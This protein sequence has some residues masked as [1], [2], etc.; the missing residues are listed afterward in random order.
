MYSSG[1]KNLMGIDLPFDEP[2]CPDL[3][4]ENDGAKTPEEIVQQLADTLRIYD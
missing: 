2:K 3:I 4:I 1:E